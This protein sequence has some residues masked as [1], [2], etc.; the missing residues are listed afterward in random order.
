MI[1]L[2]SIL[3]NIDASETQSAQETSHNRDD[4]DWRLEVQFP[5]AD[6]FPKLLEYTKESILG[7]FEAFSEITDYFIDDDKLVVQ[8]IKERTPDQGWFGINFNI[9]PGTSIQKIYNKM[10]FPIAQLGINIRG[11]TFYFAYKKNNY[12]DICVAV[13]DV[14]AIVLTGIKTGEVNYF[15]SS[16]QGMFYIFRF[17][18]FMS[19]DYLCSTDVFKDDPEPEHCYYDLLFPVIFN[20]EWKKFWRSLPKKNGM[21]VLDADTIGFIIKETGWNKEE[22]QIDIYAYKI[23]EI[24]L[25]LQAL[26]L[27]LD[28]LGLKRLASYNVL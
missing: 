8:F 18:A 25:K 10:V 4:F 7:I 23:E 11:I 16:N 12:Q 9:V 17:F 14:D 21:R 24:T 13:S 2:E 20:P 5:N 15:Q 26:K 27:M 3:D 6:K 19:T 22:F 1:L 28:I